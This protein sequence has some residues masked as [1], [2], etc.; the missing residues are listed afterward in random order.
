MGC[1]TSFLNPH[2]N[3]DVLV[4]LMLRKVYDYNERASVHL[5]I[6]R[7]SVVSVVPVVVLVNVRLKAAA[8]VPGTC[9]RSTTAVPW[10]E[11][12]CHQALDRL[13]IGTMLVA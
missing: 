11:P 2:C 7:Q 9:T 10:W 13:H 6:S 12:G 4:L 1:K 8:T 5:R 3:N